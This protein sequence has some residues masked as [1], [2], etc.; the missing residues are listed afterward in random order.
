VQMN[1]RAGA[2]SRSRP[3]R[4]VSET[5]VLMDAVRVAAAA[6]GEDGADV[7]PMFKPLQKAKATRQRATSVKM[8]AGKITID[9]EALR[10]QIKRIKLNTVTEEV[11]KKARGRPVGSKNKA[12]LARAV[13]VA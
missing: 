6:L 5:P 2:A 10:A 4:E 7:I 9:R 12:T 11:A 3:P 8:S 13:S 1:G